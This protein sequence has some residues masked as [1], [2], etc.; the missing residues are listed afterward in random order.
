LLIQS[1]LPLLIF[2]LLRHPYGPII[3]LQIPI[4][5]PIKIYELKISNR[6]KVKLAN[7]KRI[8]LR[9]RGLI[10]IRDHVLNLKDECLRVPHYGLLFNLMLSFVFNE[11]RVVES[12][13][14]LVL[15]FGSLEDLEL[16]HSKKGVVVRLV[17]FLDLC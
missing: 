2:L 4:L 14:F 13:N 11:I 8:D 3:P 9:L 6:F 7:Y 12:T 17:G 16:H 1:S 5:V 10:E 15:D